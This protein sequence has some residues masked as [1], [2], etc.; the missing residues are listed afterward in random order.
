V[1]Y[2][3]PQKGLGGCGRVSRTA[4][5]VNAYITALVLME[6]SKIALR[7]LEEVPP[8]D[9]EA[10]LKAVLAQIK[11]TTQAY[12]GGMI[13]GGRYFP[14]LD[15]TQNTA[16]NAHRTPTSGVASIACLCY[17]YIDRQRP[18]RTFRSGLEV[19]RADQRAL[20]ES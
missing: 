9:G 2:K 15:L 1:L 4:A 11:E 12:E 10:E 13:S 7:K 3:C 14:M 16:D 19:F 6:Q 17:F 18:L 5:P 20:R 8:W